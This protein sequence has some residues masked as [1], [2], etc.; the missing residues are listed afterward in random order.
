MSDRNNIGCTFKGKYQVSTTS[1]STGN[2]LVLLSDRTTTN[3][4]NGISFCRAYARKQDM[5]TFICKG[6]RSIGIYADSGFYLGNGS[7]HA[8]LHAFPWKRKQIGIVD[9]LLPTEKIVERL[10]AF[11]PV[12]IGGYP[13]KSG[14]FN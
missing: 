5:K 6:G 12:M 1:G 13:F 4:M 8:K 14:T 3:I 9:A 11:K 10:N 2:P 7:I